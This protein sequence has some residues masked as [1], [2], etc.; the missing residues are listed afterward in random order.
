[1]FIIKYVFPK[2]LCCCFL[3]SVSKWRIFLC[4]FFPFLMF[5]GS[6]QTFIVLHPISFIPKVWFDAQDGLRL[7]RLALC[8]RLRLRAAVLAPGFCGLPSSCCS[9]HITSPAPAEADAFSHP[10]ECIS[11]SDSG[12]FLLSLLFSFRVLAK[13]SPLLK[14]AH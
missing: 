8:L 6:R 14:R 10:T 3:C 9:S 4:S 2:V 1:M 12:C 7:C 13:A 11:H 5:C